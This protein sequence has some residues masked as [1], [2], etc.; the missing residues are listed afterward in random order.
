MSIFLLL[1]NEIKKRG[2]KRNQSIS[3]FV[4]FFICFSYFAT[5]PRAMNVLNR[6]VS[7]LKYYK[8]LL[9]GEIDQS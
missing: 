4:I 1:K 2:I 3:F 8:V 5:L 9:E 7:S 6:P